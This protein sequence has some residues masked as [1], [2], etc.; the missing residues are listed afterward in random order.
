MMSGPAAR[1]PGK[2]TFPGILA[3]PGAYPQPMSVI[4]AR[5]TWVCGQ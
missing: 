2:T 3:G 4:E 5:T 1:M